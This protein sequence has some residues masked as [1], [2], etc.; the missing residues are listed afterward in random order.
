[1]KKLNLMKLKTIFW[2]ILTTIII[3]LGC[4]NRSDKPASKNADS[5]VVK[6]NSTADKQEIS[7]PNKT[8]QST[9]DEHISNEEDLAI[10]P[11]ASPEN[12]V[13]TLIKAGKTGKYK[14]IPR[15]CNDAVKRDGD[16]EDICN[17]A[18]AK[19]EDQKGFNDFFGNAK[20][21]GTPRI[22]NGIAEVDIETTAEGGDKETIIVQQKYDKWYLKGL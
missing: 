9:S 13:K 18:N 20:I 5:N 16:A 15:L 14:S 8:N 11:N 10:D 6:E 4:G 2:G 17:I 7:D 1:M 22:K 21:V 12:V 3:G 19:E